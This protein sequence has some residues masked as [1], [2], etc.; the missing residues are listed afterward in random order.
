MGAV[1][2]V[3]VGRYSAG[4]HAQ[5]GTP[6][7][8]ISIAAMPDQNDQVITEEAT[9]ARVMLDPLTA[10]MVDDAVLDVDDTVDSAAHFRIKPG[11]NGV[12]GS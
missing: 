7:Y 9:G 1:A 4:T 2:G 3:F 12:D 11:K 6:D 5:S 10:E 8:S